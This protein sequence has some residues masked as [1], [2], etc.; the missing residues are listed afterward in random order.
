MVHLTL[1]AIAISF[2][3]IIIRDRNTFFN[4]FAK[5]ETFFVV[6]SAFI[7]IPIR[8]VDRFFIVFSVS[9]KSFAWRNIC[10]SNS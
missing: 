6:F 2:S 3:L 5:I 9:A 1:G 8:T 10:Y 4:Y 7:L